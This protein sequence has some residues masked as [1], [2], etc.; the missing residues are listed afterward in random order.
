MKNFWKGKKVLVTGA[1]G[2]IGS[3][4]VGELLRRESNITITISKK[5]KVGNLNFSKL[6]PQLKIERVDILSFKDCLKITKNKEIVLNFAAMDGDAKFKIDNSAEIFRNNV[7]IALNILESSRINNVNRI[8]IM[9]S[10][11]VYPPD[12]DSPVREESG[13]KEGLGIKNGYAWSK[14]FTEIIAKNYY[15]KYGLKI[16]LARPGNVYGLGDMTSKE[17]ARVIPSFIDKATKNKN[18][19]IFG[20]GSQKK[21]FLYIKDLNEA[22]FNLV[23]VYSVCDPINIAGSKYITLRDLAKLIIKLTNSKS[24]IVLQEKNVYRN[25]NRFISVEKA[26]RII[27]FQEKI[28]LTKGLNSLISFSN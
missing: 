3:N 6:F 16:A 4:A 21:S 1:A 17:K 5:K 15:D 2:F 8:L 25:E 27:G 7:Q 11:D 20:N 12:I 28:D 23:E 22:L 13:F 24:K 18:I 14:R 10:I 19:T 26:K 9:S